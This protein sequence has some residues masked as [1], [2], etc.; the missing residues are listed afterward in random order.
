MLCFRSRTSVLLLSIAALALVGCGG[1]GTTKVDK[2]LDAEW[3]WLQESK[4][5]LDALRAERAALLLKLE[6]MAETEDASEPVEGDVGAEPTVGPEGLD[7]EIYDLSDEF[8]QRLV[9][10]INDP[11]NAQIV[12]EPPTERQTA[13][14]RLKSSEDIV[15]AQEYVEKGGDYRRA[16]NI[17]EE[18]LRVDPE[19][20]DVLAAFEQAKLNRWMSQERFG[21]A[22]KGMS[23]KQ[24][25]KLLGQPL[26]SNI[27]PYPD[28]SVVA[29]FYPTGEDRGA[30]GVYFNEDESGILEAYQLKFDAV[31]GQKKGE[32]K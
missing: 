16:L 4:Q 6:E 21:A 8:G 11:A 14:L 5:S 18:A 29:W 10:F 9:G 12:G 7:S 28:K 15:M 1:A 27:R 22:E 19:N 17:L 24:V 3:A 13:A 30:A 31:A 26:P 23:G 25:R 32:E 2:A 20:D